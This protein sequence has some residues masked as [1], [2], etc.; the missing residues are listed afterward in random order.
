MSP[1]FHPSEVLRGE[2]GASSVETRLLKGKITYLK[3]ILSKKDTLVG[4]IWRELQDNYVGEKWLKD[5]QDKRKKTGVNTYNI[6]TT[7]MI[8]LR[9]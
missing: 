4:N 2:V 8:S 1:R 7:I 6:E 5:I 9:N 3:Y